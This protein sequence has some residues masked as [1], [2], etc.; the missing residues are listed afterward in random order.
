MFGFMWHTTLKLSGFKQGSANC[1]P[2]VQLPVFVNKAHNT[3]MLILCHILCICFELPGQSWVV[4]TE[5]MP[6]SLKYLLSGPVRKGL[7]T[8]GL[9][10]QWYIISH[11]PG[12]WE[13]AFLLLVSLESLKQLPSSDSLTGTEG[14]RHL[15]SSVWQWWLAS[16][17]PQDLTFIP[18]EGNLGFFLALC[19]WGSKKARTEM[20]GLSRPNLWH[21]SQSGIFITI[22]RSQQVTQPTQIQVL[23]K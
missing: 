2:W 15:F 11:N 4:V 10:Q 9:K 5:M 18:Q 23:G 6:M 14:L 17:F 22:S 3:V 1:H 20:Q 12:C 21:S 19:S 8:H 16:S 7:P 13:T